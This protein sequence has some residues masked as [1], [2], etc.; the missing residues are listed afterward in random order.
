MR[1]AALPT[2]LPYAW[3]AGEAGLVKHTRRHLVRDRGV[4]KRAIT[5][6]GYWRQG[7]SED[8]ASRENLRARERGEP[9][10]D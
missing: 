7:R 5:F 8:E 3:L 2:G 10:D 1:E 6:T 4:P 9:L